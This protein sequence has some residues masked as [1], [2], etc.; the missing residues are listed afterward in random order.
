MNTIINTSNITKKLY[1]RYYWFGNRKTLPY[2][3]VFFAILEV[4]NLQINDQ[5]QNQL[6]SGF[7]LYTVILIIIFVLLCIALF[8]YVPLRIYEK[9]KDRANEYAFNQETIE[10]ENHRPMVNTHVSYRYAG[11]MK[12][13]ERKDAFYLFIDKRQAFLVSKSGFTQGSE[14]EL[15]VLLINQLGNRFHYPNSKV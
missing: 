11:L 9:V 7:S 6:S 2:L 12:A 3:A 5:G 13:Y 4:F 15:R 1:M 8:C 14:D 10:V